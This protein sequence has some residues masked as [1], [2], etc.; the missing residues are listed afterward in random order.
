MPS[1]NLA[2]SQRHHPTAL[3]LKHLGA[4]R[5]VLAGVTSDQCVLATAADT[6]MRDY[7]VVVPHGAVASLTSERAVAHFEAVLGVRTTPAAR[8]RL[9]ERG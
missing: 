3:L 7:E 8:V 5:L 6:K 1:S 2:E 4:Q 9:G